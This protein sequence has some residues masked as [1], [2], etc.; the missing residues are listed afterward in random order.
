MKQSRRSRHE[1]IVSIN[2]RVG[3]NINRSHILNI[4][5]EQQP[6]SRVRIADIAKLNKSTVSGIVG[7][8][9]RDDLVVEEAGQ[10]SSVGRTPINLRLKTGKHLIGTLYFESRGTQLAVVDI[11]GTV[12]HTAE[13][14]C[15]NKSAEEYVAQC[16]DELCTIRKRIHLPRYKGIGVSVA[17]IV[18]SV[19]SKVVF[20][21]NLGWEDLDMLEIIRQRCPDAP[22]IAVENDAKAS[23]VAEVWFGKHDLQ[24]FNFVFLSV[25]HGI[26]TG[27]VVDRRVL[28]GESHAAGEFG[29]MTV[30]EGGE[31][32]TCGNRGCWEAY[33]SDRATVR[34]YVLLKGL[35]LEPPPDMSMR[36]VI[37]AAAAGDRIAQKALLET[38]HYLGL[39]I[40][41]IILA[42]DPE[43]IVVG[44]LIIEAWD[45]VYPEIMN[46]VKRQA[47]FGKKRNT[48]ILP[49][50]LHFSAPILGAAAVSIRKIFG[51]PVQQ[52]DKL[53]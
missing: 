8:L 4:I 3:R 15:N 33:A 39:G 9:L 14:S 42:V 12:K 22:L 23:A 29:H 19:G 1:H 51:Q 11:D 16:I 7:D 45:L 49:S 47:F 2:P 41:D 44:G 17:G 6:I 40:A 10:S 20:A 25:G 13:V 48:T 31:Y 32:C 53:H 34:R 30:V 21:P 38:G 52:R 35:P 46:T 50:A 26:G 37:S 24:L 36:Q 5:W 27:L 28:D 43:A 18:D